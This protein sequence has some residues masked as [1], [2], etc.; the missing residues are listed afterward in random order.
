MSD[1]LSVDDGVHATPQACIND[2][3]P[4]TFAGIVSLAAQLN[5]ALLAAWAAAS[6]ATAPISYEVYI[7]AGTAT[8]LFSS[9]NLAGITRNLSLRIFTDGLGAYLAKGTQYFVGVRAMDGVGNRDSNT[10]SLSATS[11]GVLSEDLAALVVELGGIADALASA[12]GAEFVAEVVE[13]T[14]VAETEDAELEAQLVC[15]D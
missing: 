13:E 12:T 8:G 15:E 2:L 1:M 14:I 9:G 11:L 7:Q 3:T 6:D 4:P 5:G 10:A